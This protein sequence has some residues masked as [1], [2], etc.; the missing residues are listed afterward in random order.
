M[1]TRIEKSLRHRFYSI[2][3]RINRI[4]L[5]LL[6]VGHPKKGKNLKV[7]LYKSDPFSVLQTV[8]DETTAYQYSTTGG[9]EN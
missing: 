5:R 7:E 2:F 6:V 3:N 8:A 1:T 9:G 4:R